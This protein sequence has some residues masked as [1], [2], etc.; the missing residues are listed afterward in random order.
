MKIRG[1]RNYQLYYKR[2]SYP[3]EVKILAYK[4]PKKKKKEVARVL[5]AVVVNLMQ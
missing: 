3:E 4:F 2:R 5:K 1:I